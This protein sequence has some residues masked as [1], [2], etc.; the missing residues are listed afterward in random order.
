MVYFT[1]AIGAVGMLWIAHFVTH[2][3]VGNNADISLYVWIM[4][5]ALPVLFVLGLIIY[6]LKARPI[7]LSEEGVTN[8][9]FGRRRKFIAWNAI[10]KIERNR[11]Y[12]TSYFM[13]RYEFWITANDTKIR[14]DDWIEDL[15]T[16]VTILNRYIAEYQIPAFS[17]DRGRDTLQKAPNVAERRKMFRDGV[18]TSVSS[19][20]C[21]DNSTPAWPR[22]PWRP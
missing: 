15:P 4:M 21:S 9:L 1:L 18:R 14:F 6:F 3:K 20:S 17:V 5:L 12:D 16:L 7:G 13:Y 19:F 8:Y 22:R 11:F 2:N 10:T